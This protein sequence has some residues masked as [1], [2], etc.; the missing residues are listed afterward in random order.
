MKLGIAMIIGALS[1]AACGSKK[2]T[3]TTTTTTTTAPAA[4]GV[5]CEQEIA[6]ECPTGQIDGCLKTPA[7][8]TTHTCVPE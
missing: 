8:G 1:L 3:T 2:S 5:P 4:E 6:L 7:E